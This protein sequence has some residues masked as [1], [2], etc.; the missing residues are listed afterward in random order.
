[1]TAAL[2]FLVLTAARPGEVRYATWKEI[3]FEDAVWRIP[4]ERMKMRKP[5]EVPLSFRAVRVLFDLRPL[6]RS[7]DD[8]L[9]FPSIRSVLRPL[10]ENAM[11]ARL[12]GLGFTQDEVTAHGFR[13]TFSTLA[14][15]SGLWT[16]DAIERQLAHV[17]GNAVR[18]AYNRAAH[19]D[20][21]VRMMTWWADQL[22]R[23]RQLSP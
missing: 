23:Y 7:D 2:K 20:E 13:A 21:R 4:A 19:W 8:R 18:R 14:N 3:D 9:I 12:R 1:L 10:S 17:D 5:H 16:S 15:E 11:N 22:D 6:Y